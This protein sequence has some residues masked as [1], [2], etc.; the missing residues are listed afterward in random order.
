MAQGKKGAFWNTISEL[1]KHFE[2][3]D[4]I[5]PSI[6][7]HRYDMVMFG[8]V[9]VH[10]SPFPLFLQWFWIWYK[11]RVLVNERSHDLM[12]VHEYSPVFN[13]VGARLVHWST[14]V[15]F[16]LEVLHV[17]G[18]P[19]TGNL[20]ELL[21]RWLFRFMIP[22]QAKSARAIRVMN[23]R[24]VPD[25]LVGAGVARKKLVHIPA[26]YVDRDVFRPRE[27]PKRFDLLYV[28]RLARNKGLK[29]FM[30]VVRRTDRKALI[31][32]DGPLR[33]WAQKYAKKHRVSVVFHGF[34][35]DQYEVAELMGSA[36]LLLMLSDSEGGPRVVPEALACGTPVLATPVGIVP[37]ILPPEAVEEWDTAALADKADNILNDEDLYVRL[38]ESGRLAL[39][40]LEKKVAIKNYADELKKLAD[41]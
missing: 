22:F 15:P 6:P 11:G 1:H 5:T 18:L 32:G 26:M 7:V 40:P 35:K 16:V 17:T 24:E 25:F 2:R 30:E 33:H 10:P 34:A 12:T 19:R 31:V 9:H 14:G 8:N 3:I 23:G 21:N 29:L 20:W 4:I 38:Q 36:R 39:E 41:A 28:G 37:D 27:L 13:G